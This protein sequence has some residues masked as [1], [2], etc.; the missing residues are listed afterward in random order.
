MCLML[1]TCSV[2]TTCERSTHYYYHNHRLPPACLTWTHY[3]WHPSPRRNPSS[4]PRVHIPALWEINLLNYKFYS[5]PFQMLGE[6]ERDSGIWLGFL[7]LR[8]W[9]VW[10]WV[11]VLS[12]SVKEN[13]PQ[14]DLGNI[15][16]K[17][18]SKVG[19]FPQENNLPHFPVSPTFSFSRASN[20][21]LGKIH[22]LREKSCQAC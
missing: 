16:S 8:S 11:S 13:I 18:S 22:I 15:R 7:S 17:I 19:V 14:S 3:L 4:P 2:F 1:A 6:L 10:E 12:K 5:D 20:D 21:N 9:G